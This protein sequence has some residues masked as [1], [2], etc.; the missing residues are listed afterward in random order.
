LVSPSHVQVMLCPHPS[1]NVPHRP[2]YST[3]HD[4]GVQATHAEFVQT[5]PDGQPQ[6]TVPPQVSDSVPHWPG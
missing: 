2:A 6:L 3:L 4:F 5:S 1:P